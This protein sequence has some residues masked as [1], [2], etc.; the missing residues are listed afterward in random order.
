[1]FTVRFFG[2][3]YDEPTFTTMGEHSVLYQEQSTVTSK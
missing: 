3:R 1:M 2:W